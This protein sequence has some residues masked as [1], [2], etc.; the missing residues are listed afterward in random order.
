MKKY[1]IAIIDPI[2]FTTKE[3]ADLK[4]Y[5]KVTRFKKR[6]DDPVRLN[7]RCKGQDIII[8]G[9][10]SGSMIE[11]ENLDSKL[12]CLYASG[13]DCIDLAKAD[14]KRILVSNAPGY[15]AISIAEHTLALLLS[16]TRKVSFFDKY[17]KSG[18][19]GA[20]NTYCTE[21]QGKTI[22]IIGLGKVGT[23]V[24]E[25]SK[26]FGMKVIAYTKHPESKKASCE[27]VELHNLLKRAD[28]ITLHLE[29]N[30]DTE[31]L[32]AKK[33][34]ELMKKGVI[35]INTSRGKIVDEKELMKNLR[36]KKVS[37]ACLDVMEKEPPIPKNQL[38]EMDNVL[39]TPHIAY[40]STESTKRLRQICID[41][42]KSFAKGS[43]RNIV[44]K[45]RD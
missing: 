41:N 10:T 14:K 17:T 43:P 45:K 28:I 16:A 26:A 7:A 9:W 38:F 25:L 23:R 13:F 36:N 37:Y 35:F 34:F 24:M 6:E 29:L 40:N 20:E 3:L 42:V 15:G 11:I 4:K 44:N 27:F 2:D 5:G 31:R 1:N 18:K 30:E 32:I 19:W 33:E 39:I 21:L 22:G 12:I 8:C